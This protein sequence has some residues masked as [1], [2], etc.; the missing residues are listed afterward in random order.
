MLIVVLF[1]RLSAEFNTARA[2]RTYSNIFSLN[3]DIIFR[4]HPDVNKEELA[5]AK[6][7]A[8]REAYELLMGKGSDRVNARAPFGGNWSFHDWYELSLVSSVA[9]W[10]VV[11][12]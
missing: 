6:F 9:I 2:I 1:F 12:L 5:E 3:L 8:L 4:Y 7:K 11:C 10:V